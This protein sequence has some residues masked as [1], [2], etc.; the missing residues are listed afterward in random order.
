MKK[1]RSASVE[2]SE[3]I[4]AEFVHSMNGHQQD[5]PDSYRKEMLIY[6]NAVS[7][8]IKRT[9][10]KTHRPQVDRPHQTG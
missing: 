6:Y 3:S 4:A 10:K 1:G 2:K 7:L 9:N 5:L 8:K